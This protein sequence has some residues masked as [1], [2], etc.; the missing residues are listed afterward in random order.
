[1]ARK[2][3]VEIQETQEE[4]KPRGPEPLSYAHGRRKT[5]VARV[6][7]YKNGGS[8]IVN[9]RP[10][11]EYFPG[12]IYKKYYLKPFELT[13]TVGEYSATIKV[14][15]SGKSGQLGAVVHGLTHALIRLNP[16]FKPV[17]KK[18]G[19]VTRDPRAKE[20]RKYGLAQKARKGKQSPKR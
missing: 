6:R 17:L 19:L 1:M 18:G 7:I 11:E 12:E 4:K 10:I 8:V 3:K 9:E 2:K 5:A 16:D 15:G 20:R 14:E 13:K